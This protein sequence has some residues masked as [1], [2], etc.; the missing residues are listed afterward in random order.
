MEKE[1]NKLHTHIGRSKF[2]IFAVVG[3]LTLLTYLLI[4]VSAQLAT[5]TVTTDSHARSGITLPIQPT[6]EPSYPGG[7][8]KNDPV[9]PDDLVETTPDSC[10]TINMESGSGTEYAGSKQFCRN[11]QFSCNNTSLTEKEGAELAQRIQDALR[12][13]YRTSSE[14]KI[15][16]STVFCTDDN[17]RS[18]PAFGLTAKLILEDACKCNTARSEPVE[19]EVRINLP[20]T[21]PTDSPFLLPPGQ[22][23]IPIPSVGNPVR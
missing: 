2:A 7:R 1:I 9:G 23:G 14:C 6:E 18:C 21:E 11:L 17:R 12:G 20:P 4:T 8:D 5:E 22:G 16:G 15:S 10:Y 13:I 3:F 19:G